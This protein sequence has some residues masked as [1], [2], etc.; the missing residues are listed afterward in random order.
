MQFRS[1]LLLTF[2]FI[3]AAERISVA[4]ENQ[5]IVR[6]D[7]PPNVAANIVES[8]DGRALLQVELKLSSMISS[9]EAA[10]IDQWLVRCQPRGQ[11]ASIVDYSPRTETGSDIATHIQVKQ[12]KEKQQSLG[13]GVSGECLP[14]LR[15][16]AGLDH[17]RKHLN[18]IQFDR[19]APVHAVT[20]AGTINRGTGV[21]FKLR[22]TAEQVLEGQK[23]FQ[24]VLDVPETWRTGLIDISVVAQSKH[25]SFAS[26]EKSTKTLGAGN[27]VVAVYRSDDTHARKVAREMAN[28]EHQLR[29][30]INEKKSLKS[31]NSISTLLRKMATKMDFDKDRTPDDLLDRLIRNQVDPHLDSDIRKLPMPC[32]LAALNYSDAQESFARL[33]EQPIKQ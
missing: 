23:T 25:K 16:N 22:W 21:Y 20:A 11:F 13:M 30:S 3:A 32:R 1:Y 28:A 17:T 18:S 4:D 7:M 5:S 26:W 14:S 15:G 29:N 8:G 12:S 31:G 10:R 33:N 19:V 2:I 27:F 24:L 6:F 9:P